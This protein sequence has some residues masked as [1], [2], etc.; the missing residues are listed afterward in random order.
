MILIDIIFVNYISLWEDNIG[1]GRKDMNYAQN[2]ITFN[3]I[4]TNIKETEWYKSQQNWN[5]QWHERVCKMTH[6]IIQNDIKHTNNE[7]KVLMTWNR[8]K[9]DKKQF[10]K[11]MKHNNN[12]IKFIYN[13]IKRLY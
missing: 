5:Q 2:D 3:N 10:Q 8:F 13:N 6:E 7:M 9:I 1:I 12:Y 4:D 11:D